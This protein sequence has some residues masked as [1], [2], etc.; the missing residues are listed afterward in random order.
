MRKNSYGIGLEEY[1][2]V[3]TDNFLGKWNRELMKE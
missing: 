3:L 1:E 2:K